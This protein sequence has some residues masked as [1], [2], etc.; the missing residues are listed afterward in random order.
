MEIK[1]KYKDKKAEVSFV[2]GDII[3]NFKERG[4]VTFKEYLGQIDQIYNTEGQ[5]E[6][7]EFTA[8][9]MIV[10]NKERL[11]CFISSGHCTSVFTKQ[12]LQQYIEVL[13]KIEKQMEG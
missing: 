6:S 12:E 4:S 2:L 5:I 13:Q 7:V 1:Y 3:E 10:E 9:R 11:G 8:Q